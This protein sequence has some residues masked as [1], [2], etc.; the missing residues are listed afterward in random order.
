M[1]Q[2]YD[3]QITVASQKGTCRAGHKVGDSWIVGHT[4]PEGICL[5]GLVTLFPAF[6]VL[7]YGGQFPW[8]QD[9]DTIDI[10]CPDDLNPLVFELRRLH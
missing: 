7:R 6:R 9:K 8:R 3:V 4:S 2:E 1:S 5:A 10:A